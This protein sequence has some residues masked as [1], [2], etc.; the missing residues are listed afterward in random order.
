[1]ENLTVDECAAR[2]GLSDA[3]SV[4]DVVRAAEARGWAANL[5]GRVITAG[6]VR[7][8]ANRL[9]GPTLKGLRIEPRACENMPFRRPIA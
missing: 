1:M 7:A 4:E 9:G 5:R 3:C 8:S 6:E 2:V